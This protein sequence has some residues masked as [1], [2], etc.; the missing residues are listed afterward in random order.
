MA[1]LIAGTHVS[2][3]KLEDLRVVCLGAG[4]AGTGIASHI[5]D[6]IA[7]KSGK[8]KTDALKQIWYVSSKV[9]WHSCLAIHTHTQCFRC[10]DKSGLLLKSQSDKLTPAQASFAKD[11]SEWPDGEGVDL[12]S[13]VRIVKP[14]VLIGTSTK[15]GAFT[16]EIVKE[17]AKHV[18]HPIIFPLSNPTR[19]HEAQPQDITKW[20]D[21]RALIATGSPFSPVKYNGTEKEI[22]ESI[23]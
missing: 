7:T 16:E 14:H 1:A 6:A 19:L 20:T 13:V 18:K 9:K 3:I 5:S 12:L 21:G 22:G 8:S 2:K 4:S 15:P 11:D 23:L 17:M 10:L